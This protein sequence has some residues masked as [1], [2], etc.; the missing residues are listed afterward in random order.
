MHVCCVSI[1]GIDKQVLCQVKAQSLGTRAMV[2]HRGIRRMAS[3]FELYACVDVIEY[4]H[5]E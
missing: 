5:Q 2:L 1:L 3:K 4:V